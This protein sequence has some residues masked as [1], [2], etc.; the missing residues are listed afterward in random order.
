[1]NAHGTGTPLND[2]MES[3]ALAR[4]LGARD[5]ARLG[6][7]Q[8]GQIG[9]TLAAAGAI[10]AAI[11]AMCV[12]EHVL[13]PTA[14]LASPDPACTCGCFA[15]PMRV[16]RVRAAVSNSFGFGGMDGSVVITEPELAAPR[17]TS[18]PRAS[19]WR[20][21]PR[22]VRAASSDAS[23]FDDRSRGVG[24]DPG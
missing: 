5:G 24:R 17:A 15:K 1:M 7:E 9:H 19:S 2:A 8:K 21:R 16:D 18:L 10:E 23:D 4:V 11:S 14:G 20:P 3:T 12:R 22:S 13:P 6:L